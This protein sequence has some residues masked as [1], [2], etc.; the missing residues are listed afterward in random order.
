MYFI[1]ILSLERRQT[2][3]VLT[4]ESVI[5]PCQRCPPT[6]YMHTW[7]PNQMCVILNLTLCS[8]N[9]KKKTIWSS[10]QRAHIMP[11]V[12]NKTKQK[13]THTHKRA[14]P[15]VNCEEVKKCIAPWLFLLLTGLKYEIYGFVSRAK[16]ATGWG[17]RRRRGN[18][19]CSN[20]EF[21]ESILSGMQREYLRCVVARG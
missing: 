4:I 17:R 14:K 2:L 11:T 12:K 3:I 18:L 21:W 1:C 16:F 10:D 6:D 20:C 15:S 19:Q 5:P 7:H 9:R 8:P 13:L